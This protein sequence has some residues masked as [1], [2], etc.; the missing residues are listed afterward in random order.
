MCF[1]ILIAGVAYGNLGSK[2]NQAQAPSP[3]M[4][5]SLDRCALIGKLLCG[6]R[7]TRILLHLHMQREKTALE[8]S[9]SAIQLRVANTAVSVVGYAEVEDQRHGY[10]MAHQLAARVRCEEQLQGRIAHALARSSQDWY[11]KDQEKR[12]ATRDAFVKI[13]TSRLAPGG[14]SL[15]PEL[16]EEEIR[17]TLNLAIQSRV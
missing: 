16:S 17:K 11:S 4:L 10:T 7:R 12:I 5:R 8:P 13:A 15:L 9:W 1:M 3:Q 6:G 14:Q 2:P